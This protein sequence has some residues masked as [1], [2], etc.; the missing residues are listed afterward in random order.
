MLDESSEDNL[1]KLFDE[2]ELKEVKDQSDQYK[3]MLEYMQKNYKNHFDAQ[4]ITIE[5][6]MQKIQE[7]QQENLNQKNQIDFEREKTEK[8]AQ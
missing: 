5:D 2:K 3:K 1:K 4:Q 6:L 8:M 7:M